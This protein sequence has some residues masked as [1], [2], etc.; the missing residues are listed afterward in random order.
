MFIIVHGANALRDKLAE[1]LGQPKEVIT[2]VKGYSS[3]YSDDKMIDL[4]MMS[5][6]GIR[7]KRIVELCHKHGINAVGLSDWMGKRFR[8][9]ATRASACIRTASRKSCG[10]SPASPSRSTRLCS[11][12]SW[13][14]AMCLC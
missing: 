6:A 14:T 9:F 13:S 8:E 2:S 7:N 4:M 12:F 1:A 3:V 5:Y 10:T 11:I